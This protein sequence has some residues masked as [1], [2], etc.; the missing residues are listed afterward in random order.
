MSADRLQGIADRIVAAR[1]AGARIAL[2]GEEVPRDYEEGFAIQDKVVAAL[3][4]PMIGWK[5]MQ[6]PGGPV[7]FA[8]ILESGRIEPGGTWSVAGT[9]P[10]G[11]ELEIA[12]R[13][14]AMCRPAS[15]RS[16]CWTPWRPP[17]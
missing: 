7:I 6:V 2:Q 9:E 13:L 4:S 12:F 15:C 14:G 10:A 5:V 1:R 8:P 11:M 17:M 16:R 3:A